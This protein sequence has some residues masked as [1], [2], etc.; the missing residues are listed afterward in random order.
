MDNDQGKYHDD[1]KSVQATNTA[2][3]KELR[4]FR[5]AAE[6]SIEMMVFTD[7]EGIVFWTNKATE[8]ITGFTVEETIG[9]KAGVLWGKLM[10][11]EWY[12]KLWHTIKVEKKMFVSEI[13]NHRKSGVRFWSTI[14]IYPLLDDNHEIEFFISTQRDITKERDIDRMKTDFI[15]IASHQM[16][17]PLTA[18]KWL[19]EIIANGDLGQLT[20][21]QLEAI[22]DVEKSNNRMIELVNGLL[23]ISRIES[24]RMIVDPKLVDLNWLIEDVKN[25]LLGEFEER[26]HNLTVNINKEIPKIMIDPKLIREVLN[27]VLTNSNKYTPHGGSVTI[28]V[29]QLENDIEFKVSDTGYGIPTN[30][31]PK[32]FERFYRGSNVIKLETNGTGLGLY[33]SKIIIES[34][35]GK[36]WID[37]IEGKGTQV[38]FTIPKSGMKAKKGEVSLSQ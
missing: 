12:A 37:S 32:I 34:S 18:M 23:N 4:R 35:G 31:L 33:L 36:I 16:R 7:P 3:I 14:T 24:G 5:A 29:T 2:L 11:K 17:T 15:S 20:N 28:D 38:T 9:K 27:N 13:E 8:R 19:L 6:Q 10:P 26:N 21:K 25:D 22:L 1:L 30:E